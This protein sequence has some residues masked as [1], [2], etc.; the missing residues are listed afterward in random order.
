MLSFLVNFAM[1]CCRTLLGLLMWLVLAL[2]FDE[3][4]V[5]FNDGEFHPLDEELM[6][7]HV[8]VFVVVE[9]PPLTMP[10]DIVDEVVEVES[11]FLDEL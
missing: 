4:V 9:P 3:V 6:V 11:W 10:W 8:L 1:T 5:I 7:G 2:P